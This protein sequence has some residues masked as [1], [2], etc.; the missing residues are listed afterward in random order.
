L[1]LMWKTRVVVFVVAALT[2]AC[3]ESIREG[4]SA[5]A[6]SGGAIATGGSSGAGG[7]ATQ[8][9]Q[10]SIIGP[11]CPGLAPEVGSACDSTAINCSYACGD[12]T[13]EM[14]SCRVGQWHLTRACG[15]LECPPDRPSFLSDCAPLEGI[16][17]RYEEDC[18]GTE[19]ATQSVVARCELSEWTLTGPPRGE[20]C[21]F[22]RVQ[23]EVGSACDLP[24]GCLNVG[25]YSISCYAQP[26]V[27]SCVDGVWRAQTLCSK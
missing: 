9:G 4:E 5:G 26:L 1:L 7:T 18:C 16:V 19:P 2:A 15:I 25:C 10:G 23:H 22:C 6:P 3:G 13:S 8:G 20:G 11:V 14:F 27:E 12:D 21:S 24:P 17:C